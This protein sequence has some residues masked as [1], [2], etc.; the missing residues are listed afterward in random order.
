MPR[1]PTIHRLKIR[2]RFLERIIT[3]EKKAEI[4]YNDRDYQTGDYIVF[5]P[6]DADDQTPLNSHSQGTWEITHV[7]TFP[8]GLQEDYV[9]L[10]IDRLP[11]QE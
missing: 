8:E 6:L 10:S 2:A 7:Q 4:R 9:V 11:P 5:I 1:K 3:E